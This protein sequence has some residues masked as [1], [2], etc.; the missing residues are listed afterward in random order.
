MKDVFEP[1]PLEDS[2]GFE[3]L[4]LTTSK[5]GFKPTDADSGGFE[6]LPLFQSRLRQCFRQHT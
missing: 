1:L 5:G 6:P 2:G 3:S 4:P